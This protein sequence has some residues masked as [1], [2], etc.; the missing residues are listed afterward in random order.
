MSSMS[1]GIG[2][3]VDDNGISV[4]S[5]REVRT[6]LAERMLAIFG[7]SL[8]L[9]PSSPD[10]QLLDLFCYAY[11][12]AA[13]SIQGGYAELDVDSANGTF[14][15]NIGRIMGIDREGRDD[16]EYRMVLSGAER[17]GLATYDN[18][19]S[20]LKA[21]VGAG[22]T[23]VANEEPT[24]DSNG[25]PGHTVALYIPQSITKTD[26]EIAQAVWTC[27]PAGIGTYGSGN[28]TA[29]DSSNTPHTVNFSRITAAG[30]YYMKITITQ[31]EEEN[32]PE[33][34]AAQIAHAVADWAVTEYS[35]GKDIIPQRA[36]QAIYR[37]P[38]IDTV[39][40]EVSSDGTTYSTDNIPIGAAYYA[41]LPYANITVV[42]DTNGGAA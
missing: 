36:I 32:L 41:S 21:H 30:P 9:S 11:N 25:V 14:L 23:L 8:D 24:T 26:D 3:Q 29:I 19:L 40:V 12:D 13:Q 2:V 16:D 6:A 18:M 7:A 10:G 35:A 1:V 20:Y 31:Y 33:D 39:L 27:K 38:G 17:T 37:V 22:I 15:D 5:Y 42:K 28:G 4:K 34:F